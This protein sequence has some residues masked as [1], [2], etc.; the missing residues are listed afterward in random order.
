SESELPSFAASLL[1]VLLPILLISTAS[2]FAAFGGRKLLGAVWPAIEFIGNR[3][4]ALLIG[5]LLAMALVVRQRKLTLAGLSALLGPA[6]ETA[7][8]IILITS[9]GGA[10]GLM[11]KH[12]GVGNAI[13][14]FA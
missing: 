9:A 7:G 4:I 10:F 1:P 11:L 12:A 6:L 3:N 8:V 2:F 13:Q 5:A 14:H